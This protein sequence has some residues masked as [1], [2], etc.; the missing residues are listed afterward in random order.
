MWAQNGAPG[1][2]FSNNAK[3]G[4]M[5]VARQSPSTDTV[6][7]NTS[8]GFSVTVGGSVNGYVNS[9]GDQDWYRITLNAGET[10]AISLTGA[11]GL[12]TYVRLLDASGNQLA[13]NDDFGGG[14]DSQLIFTATTSGTYYISAQG[15]STS[16]GAYTLEVSPHTP[17]PTL[18]IPEIADQLLNDY[19]TWAGGSARR[20]A[21]SNTDITFNVQGLSAERA[22]LARLAFA[23]WE[24][25]TGLTFTE[26][27][28]SAEI[29]LDD[30]DT[31]AYSSSTTSGGTILSSFINVE[32]GWSGGSSAID[33]YTLQTFI[34]EIGH[35]LG[36]G[37]GGNYN[38]SATYGVDNS[39]TNDTWQYT[40]MSYFTQ[41]NFGDA[42]YRYVLTPQM[43]DIYA[44]ISYY[45]EGTARAT[46]TVYGF[47]VSGH[48]ADTQVLYDFSGFASAPAITIYDTGGIDTLD[49]S[50]Y[51]QNQTISL[52]G[53]TWSDIG[54]LN[55]NVGIYLTSVIENAIGG[56]GNDTIILSSASVANLIN[57]NGGSDTVWVTY[58][59][60]TGYNI[61]FG[62]TA[63]N[64][65]MLGSAGIDTFLNVEF[66]HFA[67]GITVSTADLISSATPSGA[68]HDFNG[69]GTSDMLVRNAVSGYIS[70]GQVENGTVSAWQGITGLSTDWQ[71]VDVGDFDGD[72]RSD[73]I[74]VHNLTDGWVSIGQTENGVIQSWSGVALLSTDWQVVGAGDF[75]S[76]G[77]TDDILVHNASD[78]WVSVG[79]TE[80]GS[81][82]SWMGITLLPTGWEVV[83]VG[84]FDEDGYLDDIL[85]RNESNGWVSVGLTENGSLQSWTG[86]TQLSSDWQVDGV[87][88]YDGDG[89]SDDILVRHD[90]GYISYGETE[91]MTLISWNGVTGL[92]TDWLLIT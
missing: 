62:G 33:S 88:D 56:S 59:F 20:W 54:G 35:S 30:T 72:S 32:T 64:L 92:G 67:D 43:A 24:D 83:G 81:L 58:S 9:A 6:P 76:D 19:W 63:S 27:T 65:V 84:D 40:I 49:F 41:N 31:G 29:T 39:Y 34:H 80:N 45:G 82:Q 55:D 15:F 68:S 17:L 91:N 57:G 2:T 14:L 71:V 47:N 16:T 42:S 10:Y 78:G 13:V 61:Q 74:L 50:G 11:N 77:L 23:T 53:G 60:G 18:T 86:I 8:T 51:S 75:D 3:D 7:G 87:G 85:V 4:V 69:D 25:V 48:D 22:E 52:V 37:H 12:D 90:S 36:L 46:D 28:G 26:V 5:D 66:V 38:G 1:D 21:P 73:D 79:L 89:N 70:Y 44:L